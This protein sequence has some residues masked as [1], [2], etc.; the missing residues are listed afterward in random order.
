MTMGCVIY[1]GSCVCVVI[2]ASVSECESGYSAVNP[3]HGYVCVLCDLYVLS[4]KGFCVTNVSSSFIG[5]AGSGGGLL[6]LCAAHVNLS[7][8]S[9]NKGS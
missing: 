4:T 9:M 6:C 5:H 7:D 1:F 2:Y 8:S 3:S